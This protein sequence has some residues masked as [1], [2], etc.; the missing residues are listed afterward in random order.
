MTIGRPSGNAWIGKPL[1]LVV[2]LALDR[3][4]TGDGLCLEADVRQGDI[5]VDDKRVTLSLEPG[6]SPDT[7]RVRLR[8]TRAIEEPVVTVT[9]TAGCDMKSTRQYVLLADLPESLPVAASPARPAFRPAANA[10]G[11]APDASA[12][13]PSPSPR[14]ARVAQVPVMPKSRPAAEAVPKP[15]SPAPRPEA[16]AAPAPAGAAKEGKPRLQVEPLSPEP[17]AQVAAKPALASP[18]PDDPAGRAQAQALSQPTSA[19]TAE[20][21]RRDAER[22]KELESALASVREQSAQTQRL[23]LEMRADLAQAQASRYR[24]PLVYG[25]LALIALALIALALLWRTARRARVSAW[26]GGAEEQRPGGSAAR[27]VLPRRGELIEEEDEDDDAGSAAPADVSGLRSAQGLRV[28]ALP[29]GLGASAFDRGQVRQVNAEELFDVQQQSEF[30]VSLGQHEQA[31]GV[32]REHI[33]ANPGTSAL[34]YLDLLGVLHL[35]GRRDDYTTLAREFGYKFNAQVPDFENYSAE[36]RSLEHYRDALA[37]IMEQ[38]PSPGTAELI[39]AFVFRKPGSHDESFD[40]PAYQELLLLYAV[41]RDLSEYAGPWEAPAPAPPSAVRQRDSGASERATQ[42]E[43][44]PMP[45]LSEAPDA[46][47]AAQPVPPREMPP[48]ELDLSELDRTA[49]ETLPAPIESPQA[50]KPGPSVDP[51]VID[52]DP[53]DP[54]TDRGDLR[55]RHLGVKV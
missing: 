51:H 19:A 6:P 1:E 55:P 16:A 3:S 33:A 41:A 7:P 14:P 40:L 32:L 20:Q 4:D 12:A 18:R 31:I 39:E 44:G 23:L 46:A 28:T 15:P 8:T 29:A 43:T 17:V 38:W 30:F 13:L 5:R 52:F 35:L 47:S 21:S 49:F 11:A 54:A 48:L 22:M 10:S 45:Y 50:Q 53:S 24:N 27:P 34:A 2:P 42:Q 25:L 36:G 9:L 37:R 26:W